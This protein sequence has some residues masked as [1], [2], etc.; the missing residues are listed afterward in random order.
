[1]LRGVGMWRRWGRWGRGRCKGL[2]G[3]REGTGGMR[4]LESSLWSVV[5]LTRSRKTESSFMPICM[6]LRITRRIHRCSRAVVLRSICRMTSFFASLPS[7]LAR[8]SRR[9]LSWPIVSMPLISERLSARCSITE[10]TTYRARGKARRS[11]RHGKGCA[12]DQG[13]QQGGAGRGIA[14]HGVA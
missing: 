10:K 12:C 3:E 11:G 5:R 6:S 8:S 13:H 9:P 2:G 1:M 14:A 4:L 7:R